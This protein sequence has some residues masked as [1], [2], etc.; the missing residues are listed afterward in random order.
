MSKRCLGCGVIMQ[1]D[2]E[3]ALGYTKSLDMDY[4]MR[5]FRLIHYREFAKLPVSYDENKILD[6]MKKKK[7]F[8]FY[9]VDFLNICKE[10][11]GHYHRIA[12]PK[13]LLISKSDIIPKSIYIKKVE[14]WL[15]KEF[16]IK[17]P[18]LFVSQKSKSSQKKVL[19]LMENN[20]ENRFYFLGITN[21]GKST[22]LNS[23]LDMLEEENRHIAVSEMPDT[24]LDFIE[25]K[26]S[27]G[28][29]YDSQ[30]FS[31]HYLDAEDDLIRLANNKKEM[32]PITYQMKETESLI[33]ENLIRL[34]SDKNNSITFFGS[35]NL[36][37]QKVYENNVRLKNNHRIVVEVPNNSQVVLK[38]I[39][40]FYIKHACML[41]LYGVR[42]YECEV[43]PSFM[44]GN[45]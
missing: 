11:I 8:V 3:E 34:N 4:C 19:E 20:Q 13:M 27:F 12:S 35:A 1:S 28:T 21:A 31:Y 45:V 32:K 33:L 22:F 23:L 14:E 39:G 26:L 18:I 10:T 24:T 30:G 36:K 2:N 6:C 40:F 43:I 16:H 15:N 17:D 38:G 42:E 29:I 9:F 37:L 41:T 5:C 25:I 7:G 44:G